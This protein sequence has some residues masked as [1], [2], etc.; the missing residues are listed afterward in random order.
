MS[1]TPHF[2]PQLFDFLRDLRANNDRDW[3]KANKA[4][5]EDVARDPVLRFIDDSAEPLASITSEVRA[6]PRP[7]GG[8]LFRI[9]RDVRFSHDKSPYKTHIGA[10]FRHR[11]AKDV[12]CPGYYLHLEPDQ[13]FVAA[14]IWRPDGPSLKTL[15]AAMDSSQEEWLA[16]RDAPH[17]QEHFHLA[18]DSLKR[19]PKGYTADH[20]LIE[21]LKR[22]DLIAMTEFSEADAC[23]DDFFDRF[24]E[25]CRQASPFCAFVARSLGHDW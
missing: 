7:V 10:Q 21:D 12:H 18:G 2:T 17:F 1:P 16:L 3:F 6:D 14:G 20:P 24:V 13:V 4:R 15:R 19:P 5:Y 9:Y 23:A 11:R 22:K 25:V 8:S